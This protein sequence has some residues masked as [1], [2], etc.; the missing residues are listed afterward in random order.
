VLACICAALSPTAS[1]GVASSP[2]TASPPNEAALADQPATRGAR[3]Q[4]APVPPPPFICPSGPPVRGF[5]TGGSKVVAFTFDDG[6]WPVYTDGVMDAFDARGV[7]ATFFMIASNVRSNPSIAQDVVNR[8]FEVGNHTVTHS[9]T[10][11]TIVAEIPRAN[12]IIQEVT[13]VEPRLFRAPGLTT[14]SRI[15]WAMV[16]YGMCNLFTTYDLG[17]WKVPRASAS[18]LCSRVAGSLHP[19][20]IVLLHDG[21]THR[22][23]VD[24][25]PCMLDVAISRG[26]TIVPAGH[27]GAYG[28]GYTGL[29]PQLTSLE[30]VDQLPFA[31]TE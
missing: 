14:S 29:R 12:A 2:L 18:T 31:T 16:A 24:A 8:G 15:D 23:T 28:T 22:N 3:T 5:D 13:G 11:S 30:D 27:L 7:K 9:Y 26:Y 21:G 10:P 1:V 25:V 6:P 4:V 17:D 20:M 19:G